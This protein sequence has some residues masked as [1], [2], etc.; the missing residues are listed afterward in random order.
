M[1]KSKNDIKIKDVFELSTID[2]K[3]IG[4]WSQ[5]DINAFLITLR[6]R[7]EYSEKMCSFYK[8]I[9]DCIE[10]D[11][12]NLNI[13]EKENPLLTIYKDKILIPRLN[14][15]YQI[16]MKV[17]D[18]MGYLT[19]LQMD[20]TTAIISLF[21]AKND[22]ERIMQCKHA[23][24][25][26][27][28]AIEHNM[29]K[30]V[31]KEIKQYPQDILQEVFPRKFWKGIRKLLKDMQSIDEA[32]EIRNTIDAHKDNSF[33]AHLSTYQKCSWKK[34]VF[35]LT[36]LIK[37]IEDIQKRLEIV[38]DNISILPKW[39]HNGINDIFIRTNS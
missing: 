19:L 39:Y 18:M 29:F 28:E 14:A 4:E 9:I 34:S 12:D 8:Y 20:A 3:S 27:Y 33:K 24:T 5:K 1:A 36:I 10:K 30:K 23:Y 37:I 26:I 35:N 22:T 17:Y 2:R 38:Y 25:I 31:S 15:I 21:Q 7:L 16:R 32:K 6:K 11:I 13:K